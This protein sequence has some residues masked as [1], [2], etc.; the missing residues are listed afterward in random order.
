MSAAA[1][2]NAALP[3]PRKLLFLL[4]FAPDIR[5][6]HGGTRACAAI[7]SVLALHHH[8]RVLYLAPVDEHP[9]RELPT[10]CESI[11]PI[12]VVSKARKKQG[13]LMRLLATLG[14][15]WRP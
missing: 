12:S 2:A 5:G 11:E 4:P 10:G 13:A 6:S 9:P 14:S 15:A 3:G 8:V 1:F 7:I